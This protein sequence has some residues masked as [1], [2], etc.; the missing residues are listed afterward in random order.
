MSLQ[1]VSMDSIKSEFLSN[2]SDFFRNTSLQNL[3]TDSIQAFVASNKAQVDLAW[4]LF[5]YTPL[6]LRPQF[7]RHFTSSKFARY[8]NLPYIPLLAHIFLGIVIVCRYQFR[9]VSSPEPPRPETLD[10]AMGVTNAILS[11][12]LCKYE[13]RGNPRLAR[14]GFQVL[15]LMLLFSALMCYKTA[16]PVWYHALAKTHNSFIYVR[17]LLLGGPVVGLFDGYHELYTI[18]VFFG[19]ILGVW[20]GRFP[21]DGILGAPL[22]LVVHVVLVIMERWTSSLVTAKLIP[23]P[24]LTIKYTNDPQKFAHQSFP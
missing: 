6:V 16:S 2:T 7:L 15:A 20:E 24:F 3:S 22:A 19:G 13:H 12:R 1:S 8:G 11:W 5:I 18:S 9:A 10:I 4:H 23:P 21:W 17:W 14:V